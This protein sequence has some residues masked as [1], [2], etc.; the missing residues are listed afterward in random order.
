MYNLKLDFKKT[1]KHTYT[2]F[3]KKTEKHLK[4]L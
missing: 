4:L 3:N 2:K 1:S